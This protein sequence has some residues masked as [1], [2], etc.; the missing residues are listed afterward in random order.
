MNDWSQYVQQWLQGQ[1]TPAVGG[2]NRS[3]PATPPPIPMP[4]NQNPNAGG[5]MQQAFQLSGVPQM[6]QQ[7]PLAGM[8]QGLPQGLPQGGI[9]PQ[10]QQILTS[11]MGG[12]RRQ[13]PDIPAFDFRQPGPD[14]SR[15]QILQA[16]MGK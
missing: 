6:P 10:Y 15:Q 2:I 12:A 16:L 1:Q 13:G 9:P 3:G 11:L 5:Y 4:G 7:N 8:P 14:P